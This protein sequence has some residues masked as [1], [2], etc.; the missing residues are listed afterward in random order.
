MSLPASNVTISLKTQYSAESKL[1]CE[2]T[3]ISQTCIK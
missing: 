1:K 2:S 3:E